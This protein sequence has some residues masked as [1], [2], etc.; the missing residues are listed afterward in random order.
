MRRAGAPFFLG[1]TAFLSDAKFRKLGRR[2]TDPDDFN[3]AVG[4]YFIGLAAARRNGEPDLDLETET[5][6]RFLDDLREVGLI[7]GAG[8]YHEPFDA[9]APMSPQQAA[10]GRARARGAQRDDAGK[11]VP[12][13]PS[14]ASALDRLD[15]LVQPSLPLPSLQIPSSEE[16]VQGEEPDAAV[17]FNRRTGEFP[18]GK[19]LSWINELAQTHGER[20]LTERIEQTPMEGRNAAQYLR[21]VRDLLR[22]EDHLAEK[23]ERADEMRR[24]EE[25]RRPIVLHPPPDDISDEEAE[26]QAREYIARQKVQ[27]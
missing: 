21:A 27:S 18:G 4:A 7:N 12:A 11:F 9:W 26:R 23:A 1:D 25:K 3:S 2:L 22:T 14:D 10:A 8:F 19:I 24:L 6:S 17:A 5:G 13:S 16:G 15:A 20:R